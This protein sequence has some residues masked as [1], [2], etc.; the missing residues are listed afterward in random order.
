MT[1]QTILFRDSSREVGLRPQILVSTTDQIINY[2]QNF[3][4]SNKLELNMQ[5]KKYTGNNNTYTVTLVR[6]VS[7]QQYTSI[8]SHIEFHE[9]NKF[10]VYIYISGTIMTLH[11]YIK[12]Y[13]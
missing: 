7:Y 1:I 10:Y 6:H 3:S 4:Y 11:I 2:C 13:Q 12:L 9:Q 8:A 5:N